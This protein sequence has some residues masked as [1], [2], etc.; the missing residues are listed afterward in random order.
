MVLV[1]SG[2]VNTI[3]KVGMEN[4]KIGRSLPWSLT[5]GSYTYIGLQTA[6]Y[7]NIENAQKM[8]LGVR[9]TFFS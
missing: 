3:R 6:A 9:F 1:M 5:L 8:P 2:G 4:S 7:R